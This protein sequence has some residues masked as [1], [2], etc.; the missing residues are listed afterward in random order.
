MTSTNPHHGPMAPPKPPVRPARPSGM[1]R[2][3]AERTRTTIGRRRVVNVVMVGI[4]FGAAILTTLPLLFILAHLVEAGWINAADSSTQGL[5]YGA[6]YAF[7]HETGTWTAKLDGTHMI[8]HKERS[9]ASQPLTQFVGKFGLRTL[10]SAS[11]VFSAHAYHRGSI[12]PF[13]S[14]IGWGGL[15]AAGRDAEAEQVRSG[16]LRALDQLGR[17]PELYA[18]TTDGEVQPVALANR[19]QAWTIGARSAL[20]TRW[21]GRQKHL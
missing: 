4:T 2:A 20:E 17:A 5:D 7:K 21:D 14:W 16:V 8:S 10:S 1:Q 9:I 15:R 6:S 13:D 19:V 18:V 3:A 11:P 12:W